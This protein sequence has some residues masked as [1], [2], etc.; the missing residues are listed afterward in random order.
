MKCDEGESHSLVASQHDWSFDPPGHIAST[1]FFQ[2]YEMPST[3]SSE[4]SKYLK[5]LRHVRYLLEETKNC[6]TSINGEEFVS[7]KFMSFEFI[8]Q[9]YDI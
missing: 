7:G 6:F 4:I 8:Q 3:V 9:F 2:L 1:P 5:N